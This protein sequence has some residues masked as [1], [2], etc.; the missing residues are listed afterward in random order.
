MKFSVPLPL[1]IT[2]KVT[3]VFL[4]FAVL[5]LTGV[6]ALAYQ[7]GRDALYRATVS[8]LVSTAIEKEAA[9][10]AWVDHYLTDVMSIVAQPHLS[11]QVE[12]LTATRMDPQAHAQILDMLAPWADGQHFL[13]LMVLDPTSGRVLVSTDRP[14]EGRYKENRLY[15]LRGRKALYL[16]GPYYSVT[17]LAPT[18]VAAAPIRQPDG[19][20]VGVLAA[21]LNLAELNGIMARRTGLHRTDDAYLVNQANLFVTMPRLVSDRADYT[22]LLQGIYTEPVDRCLAGSSGVMSGEGFQD[23]QMITVYRWLPEWDLCLVVEL[24]EAEAFER[25][26]RFERTLIL[27]GMGAL[28]LASVVAVGVARTITRPVRALQAGVARFT[29]GDWDVRLPATSFDE[30]GLL[31]RE[32]NQ[33]AAALSTKE[34]QLYQRAAE[35]QQTNAELEETL[36]AQRDSEA[37]YRLLA[38]HATDMI[39]R[40]TPEG[41]YLYVSPACRRLLGYDPEELVGRNAYEFVHPDDLG[42]VGESHT[43][44]L[45]QDKIYTVSYRLWQRSGEYVWVETT[46]RAVLDPDSGNVDEIIA[47]TRDISDRKLIETELRKSKRQLLQ[48]NQEL[49]L[50]NRAS[51]AFSSTLD[52]DHV[53]VM[54]L[55]EVRALLDVVACSIWLIDAPSGGL[56][57][58]QSIGPQSDVVRGWRLELG[59]GIAGWAAQIGE[60]LIVGDVQADERYFAGVGEQTGLELRSIMT[61]PLHVVS[62]EGSGSAVIGVI[63][64]VDAR[65]NRF[66]ET[67]LALLESLAASAA[68]SIEN[69]RLYEQ[70]LQD[71]ET[72]AVLLQEANHRI[73]NNL[74]SIAG[75]LYAE[76]RHAGVEEQSLY[77][78]IIRDLINRV[79]GLAAVHGLLASN[80]WAPVLL[81]ELVGEVIHTALQSLPRSKSV[82]VDVARSAVRVSP[83]TARD[84]ALVINELATN[85]I[86]H[87]LE[88]RDEA[89]ITVEMD[90]EMDVKIGDDQSEGKK[91]VCLVYRDDG[92]GYPE[93]VLRGEGYNVGLD[94][95][96]N[97]VRRRLSGTL[98]LCNDD[99][100]GAVTVMRF[101][102]QM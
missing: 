33:M 13:S 57:C 68:V 37:R 4:L 88:G 64:V 58:Q 95:A 63:Q 79:Q 1:S 23:E 86:R 69:A 20:L 92:P 26:N 8:D 47:I 3:L 77:R 54:V 71:A 98:T 67:D 90:V 73:R 80:E 75:L 56:V 59:Q 10:E 102:L 44:I 100:G 91:F 78:A 40:H 96:Q 76:L 94:L 83:D 28:L 97:S 49:A 35:L 24:S 82:F 52:L 29:Q 11:E 7:S 30:L 2:V 99:Q 18:M 89:R 62:L 43:T 74:S 14:E 60:S 16:Q 42:A 15:F 45:A 81:S 61:V 9:L 27:V 85:T 70:A 39:S 36:E 93:A 84:L 72:K 53:L 6:G 34:T 101:K 46:S 22:I 19:R 65:V 87:A 32:F 12:V 31:T 21:R 48:R 38:E 41:K 66:V 25:A 51:R 50:L 55:E 5:M 17:L